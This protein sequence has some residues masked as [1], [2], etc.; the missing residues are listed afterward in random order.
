[1]ERFLESP[2]VIFH[3]GPIPITETVVVSWLIMLALILFGFL[4]T[5]N[6]RTRPRGLQT[7]T[8]LAVRA[9][10]DLIG[11]TMGPDKMGFLGYMGS[12]M[13]FIVVAN[14]IGIAGVRPP[15]SDLN[16]TMGL[17]LLT[18]VMIQLYGARSHGVGG[19]I[20]TLSEPVFFL[21]PLNIIGELAKPVS[22]GVR[23]FGNIVGGSIIM[24]MIYAV[25]PV[26]IPMPFH[27]YFDVFVGVIQTFIFAALTMVFVGLAME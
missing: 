24:A 10:Q 15:T 14:V 26:V 2:A 18:F 19:Y 20:K 9:T 25:I 11:M 27:L 13:A 8:E 17:A 4:L 21:L 23:L 16:I 1:M 3:I 6:L 5:R 7:V 22:L 12:L